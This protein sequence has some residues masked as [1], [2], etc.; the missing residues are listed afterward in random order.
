MSRIRGLQNAILISSHH[1]N[2]RHSISSLCESE[3]GRRQT[4][5]RRLPPTERGFAFT[6]KC[7]RPEHSHKM[8]HCACEASVTLA[9]EHNIGIAKRPHHRC[10]AFVLL[11]WSSRYVCMHGFARKCFPFDLCKFKVIAFSRF[12]GFPDP[13]FWISGGVQLCTCLSNSDSFCQKLSRFVSG[14]QS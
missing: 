4:L 3:R 10:M 8:T 14:G 11:V 12:S 1:H 9:C 5:R 13:A 6:T 2:S 7:P